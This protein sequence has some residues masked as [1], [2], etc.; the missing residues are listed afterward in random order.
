M[1]FKIYRS[2]FGLKKQSCLLLYARTVI[3][4]LSINITVFKFWKKNDNYIK[5]KQPKVYH[6]MDEILQHL[7]LL[8]SIK[9]IFDQCSI[10]H[11]INNYDDIK[12]EL[13]V[14]LKRDDMQFKFNYEK[15]NWVDSI[16][17]LQWICE[18]KQ[19]DSVRFNA[20]LFSQMFNYFDRRYNP[21][22]LRKICANWNI[23]FD[24]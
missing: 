16:K 19:K 14:V 20:K 21:K 17:I 2:N 12:K 15:F 22:I 11:I 4:F 23:F 1:Y 18:Q 8:T 13:L 10:P 5:K 9:N 6:E 24:S 7:S 3:L